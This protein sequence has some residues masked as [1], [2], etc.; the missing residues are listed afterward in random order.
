[1]LKYFNL[2]HSLGKR[3]LLSF[4]N[5]EANVRDSRFSASTL[6][7]FQLQSITCKDLR[8]EL[9]TSIH[10]HLDELKEH[11]AS[12]RSSMEGQPIEINFSKAVVPSTITSTITALRDIVFK[13]GRLIGSVVSIILTCSRFRLVRNFVLRMVRGMQ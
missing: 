7:V 10:H 9:V 5:S 12:D 11:E 13:D 8:L 6:K 2:T 4:V 1:M 3:M